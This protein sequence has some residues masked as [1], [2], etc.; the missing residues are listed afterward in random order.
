MNRDTAAR[1]RY[2][3]RMPSSENQP[4]L[5]PHDPKTV[6]RSTPVT[7]TVHKPGDPLVVR[8]D[9]EAAEHRDAEPRPDE[10]DSYAVPIENVASDANDTIRERIETLC[11]EAVGENPPVG[12]DTRSPAA[13]LATRVNIVADG[14][15]TVG[16]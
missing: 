4:D 12:I 8:S 16:S 2:N 14:K 5:L 9:R 10:Y 3:P 15:G 6:E 11:E 7:T 13:N 1:T